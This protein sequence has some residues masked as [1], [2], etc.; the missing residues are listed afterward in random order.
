MSTTPAGQ[1]NALQLFCQQRQL[2]VNLAK[3]NV[4]TFGS[5]ARCQTFTFNGNEVEHVQSYKYLGFEFHATKKLDYG[6]SKL[7]SAANKAMHAMNRRCAFWHISDPKQRC[8]LFDSLVLPIL[9][10]AS[11][12]WAVDEEVG[13]SAEQLHRQFLKHV[14]GD[15]GTT[16]TL[17]VLA[18]NL[19]KF[20]HECSPHGSML[21]EG[22]LGVPQ[23]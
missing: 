21:L 8:K 19:A 11:Q 18:V 14:H 9:S 4:V 7:V 10:Y 16:A 13:K 17:I 20:L 1:L 23:H 22:V 3:I 15:R 2:S 6:V 5:G 12:V